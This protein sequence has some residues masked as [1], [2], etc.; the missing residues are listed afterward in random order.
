MASPKTT[1]KAYWRSLEER[2]QTP[3]FQEFLNR[4]FPVGASEL[5]DPV[6]RRS[7]LQLMGGSIA[8]AGA[9]TGCRKPVQKILP[10]SKMPENLIEGMPRYYATTIE[11]SGNAMGLLARSTEGRP[12]KLEGNPDFPSNLGATDAMTQAEILNLYD[13]DRAI[14]PKQVRNSS[15]AI[16]IS[17][18]DLDAFLGTS[19]AALR[20]KGGEGLFFLS[21]LSSSPSALALRERL[22]ADVFPKAQWHVWEPINEDNSIG[23]AQL[24]FGRPLRAHYDFSKA[25]IV[26]SLDAD[27]LADNA[28]SLA[29]I[30]HFSR[31]RKPENGEMNRLYCVE[32]NF[33][34]TGGMADHRLRV[35][36]SQIEAFGLALAAELAIA[37]NRL[38]ANHPL[39]PAL[40]PHAAGAAGRFN[41]AWIAALAKDMVA[42]AGR[43]VILVGET[44]S[45][46]LHG[47]AAVLNTTLGAECVGYTQ[48]PDP[49]FGMCLQSIVALT[50]ALNAKRVDTLVILGGNPVYDAPADLKFA[51]ALKLAPHSMHLSYYENETSRH[52]ETLIPRAHFLESWGDARALDGT[53]GMTQPL[54]QPIYGGISP[55]ELLA[56]L[57][58]LEQSRGYDLVRAYHRGTKA[59]TAFSP[60]WETYLHDGIIPGSAYPVIPGTTAPNAAA[61]AEA[62]RSIPAARTAPTIN[63]MEL[64]F[65]PDSRIHDGRYANNGWLQEASDPV[66][67]LTWDNAALMSPKTARELGVVRQREADAS[68]MVTI[69]AD[70]VTLKMP[71]WPLPGLPD[72]T[73][74]VNLGYG[75][76]DE[77][78]I[79]RI[80]LN[81]GWNIYPFRTTTAMNYR[82]GVKVERSNAPDFRLA[83]TQDH[84]TMHSDIAFNGKLAEPENR[85]MVVE[86]DLEDYL[87][88]PE[89]FKHKQ[90]HIPHE[91]S[92]HLWKAYDYSAG[93][94]WGMTIDLSACS[95][96]NACSVACQAENNIPIVG[97]AQVRKGREM[98]WLRLDR[99]FTGDEDDPQMV[100]QAVTCQHC[101]TA[102][103]E[104]VCPVAATTHSAD[105]LNEMTYNRCIGTRYCLNNCPYKVR[106]F[107]F[108]N[109]HEGEL[110]EGS[111]GK[112]NVD[113]VKMAS[114]PDVTVRMRGVMEKCT[115][116]VQRINRKRQE[117][118]IK[119]T[120]WKDGDVVT[121]CQAA[122]P[123]E[124]ITFGDITIPDS[125]VSLEKAK[126]RNYMLLASLRTK[127][128]L[129]YLGKIR[130]PNPEIHA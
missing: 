9:L 49:S 47:L 78:A 109:Y 15:E 114:N 99:Y 26:V 58:G 4:E 108:F 65:L 128:R 126:A 2:A 39:R 30:R 119:G 82:T 117:H 31:R 70:G 6:S 112:E 28:P 42:H 40:E 43:T 23:G 94:Q 68:P 84:W 44:H 125:K 120:S 102:P 17:Q 122:C 130:N 106:R 75:H 76:T 32:S 54:I 95:G 91:G 105:G 104:T 10:Y 13:P 52:V 88:H 46:A 21:E 87:H 36:A 50:E 121:A 73:V 89:E 107:N 123:A 96:C 12:T 115:F 116:C 60:I 124:A 97:R 103:C 16:E 48:L 20:A 64:I 93:P 90:E 57:G 98:S 71:A 34:V 5:T 14:S 61:V 24:A 113:L 45:P 56:R 1:G 7:F 92:D 110:W 62:V 83:C 18:A 11:R 22:M 8:L 85:A 51:E 59:D 101:E 33:S 100:M 127:P 79:G 19:G 77:K 41:A 111:K 38:P 81:A 27:F 80:G 35:P 129:T 63:A 86:S 66:T 69:E 72:Y 118:K 53:I 29:A 37:Q 55:I 3:E 67:K 25:D 74:L